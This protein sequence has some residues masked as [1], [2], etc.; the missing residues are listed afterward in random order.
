MPVSII[1]LPKQHNFHTMK[2][3]FAFLVF[4]TI[5]LFGCNKE[6]PVQPGDN[7]IT[8]GSFEDNG[9]FSLDGW[10][11]NNTSSSTDVPGGGGSFSLKIDPASSPAEGY[12]EFAV[13]DLSGTK[14]FEL[15]A[16]IKSF[17]DWPGSVTLKKVADDGTITIL[18]T[19]ASSEN[20]W[21]QKT[22]SITTS[23]STG[24]KLMVHI[25][26]GSTEAPTPDHYALFDL[27]VLK[28]Q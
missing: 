13:E 25:S 2:S 24:D 27:L 8:N 18:A 1:H 11:N 7:L 21:L 15:T 9:N 20:S 10:T 19:D 3:K 17:G 14:S 6:N 28:E 16:F 4:A 23:F 22:L 5:I 26:S 12:A